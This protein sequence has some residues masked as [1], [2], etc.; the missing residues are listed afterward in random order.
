MNSKLPV[1]VLG[2]IWDLSDI[3]KDGF[4][5]RDEFAVVS[6]IFN[7]PYCTQNGQNS[8]KCN[9]VKEEI[10]R[11]LRKITFTCNHLPLIHHRRTQRISFAPK[12]QKLI[13]RTVPFER[14]FRN[15]FAY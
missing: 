4:L 15:Q 3:D 6:I 10:D 8:I 11:Q 13:L 7:K 9:R 14:A 12:E 1:D 2:R 5:D